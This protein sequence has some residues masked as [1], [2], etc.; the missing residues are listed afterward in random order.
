MLLEYHIAEKNVPCFDS[1]QS[2]EEVAAHKTIKAKK[3][4]SFIFDAYKYSN[5]VTIFEGERKQDFAPVKN[6]SGDDSPETARRMI[7]FLHSTWIARN[8]GRIQWGG[9]GGLVEVSPLV[10][11]NGENLEFLNDR[12]VPKNTN[13]ELGWNPPKERLVPWHRYYGKHSSAP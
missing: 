7:S 4:E 3:L 5:G 8:K 2:I 9:Y 12:D 11:L 10:S 1:E 6:A 13:V